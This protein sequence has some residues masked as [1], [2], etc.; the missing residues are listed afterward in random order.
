MDIQDLRILARVAAVQNLSAVGLELGLTPGTI[1]KRIQSVED[2][3]K[4]RLFDRTTRSIRLTEEGQLFL[5]RVS[6]ILEEL[7]LARAEVEDNTAAPRGRLKIAAP[8]DLGRRSVAP[9]VCEFMRAYPEIDVHVDLTDR[10]VNLQEDGYD[11]AIRTGVLSDSALIAKR[12]ASDP[13]VVVASPDYIARAGTPRAPEDLDRHACLV[14]CEQ[15]TWSFARDDGERL[16]RV[17][18]RLRSNSVDVLRHAALEGQG[19]IRV[20]Q[21]R[22]EDDIAAGR[23]VRVL[24]EY[25]CTGKSAVWALYPSTKHVLPRLRVLLDF[26]AEWFRAETPGSPV[27]ASVHRLAP[28]APAGAR[29]AG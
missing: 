1:S 10:L 25:D 28:S 8:V 11:I 2:D 16:V 6:R 26:L 13:Q 4:V 20:S 23:L 15:W 24:P 22:V 29:L 27:S 12:L 21:L 9:L 19:L 3:L 5:A 18:G 14:L 17:A 7:E